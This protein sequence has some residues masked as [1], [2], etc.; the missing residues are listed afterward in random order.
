MSTRT[1]LATTG[2][3]VSSEERFSVPEL[4]RPVD[5]IEAAPCDGEEIEGLEDLRLLPW[6]SRSSGELVW[7]Q[8][9]YLYIERYELVYLLDVLDCQER[10]LP[11]HQDKLDAIEKL[12]RIAELAV[13][14]S[15]IVIRLFGS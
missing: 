15:E 7:H 13:R 5:R 11:T 3:K 6:P 9:A 2:F 10:A 14:I 4:E 8:I 12:G 1:V